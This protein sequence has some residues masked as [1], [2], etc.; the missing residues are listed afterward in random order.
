MLTGAGRVPGTRTTW[1][2]QQ[3]LARAM[4]QSRDGES[5]R[6]V[7]FVAISSLLVVDLPFFTF[8]GFGLSKASLT[9]LKLVVEGTRCT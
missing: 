9:A 1:V 4:P 5:E 7:G 8:A 6:S 3:D 2:A